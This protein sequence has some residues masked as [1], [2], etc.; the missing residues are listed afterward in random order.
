MVPHGVAEGGGERA[1]DVPGPR[2]R[3][4]QRVVQRSRPVP[5]LGD[6]HTAV[7]GQLGVHVQAEGVPLL[8]A[9]AEP[10]QADVH[11]AAGPAP[12]APHAVHEARRVLEHNFHRR[13][14]QARHLQRGAV[15]YGEEVPAQPV[16]P[17]QAHGDAHDERHARGG[18][19]EAQRHAPHGAQVVQRLAH[20][21]A[22]AAAQ[23]PEHHGERDEGREQQHEASGD[24]RLGRPQQRQVL[25][26]APAQ[27]VPERVRDDADAHH[28]ARQRV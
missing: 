23:A 11:V 15:V 26:H 27:Q 25:A 24:A 28:G 7:V 17:V 12:A 13:L 1:V 14:A 22:H 16:S 3:L 10:G 4:R 19:V 18:G 5:H 8:L 9:L 2:R 20:L 6:A 21:E